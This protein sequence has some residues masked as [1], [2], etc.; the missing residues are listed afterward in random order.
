MMPLAEKP[1]RK[2][3]SLPPKK[4]GRAVENKQDEL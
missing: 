4:R 1:N 2:A 3:G